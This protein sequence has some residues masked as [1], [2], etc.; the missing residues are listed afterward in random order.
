MTEADFEK[1]ITYAIQNWTTEYNQTRNFEPDRWVREAIQQAYIDGY[2]A[3]FE[4]SV[5][6]ERG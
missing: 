6:R 4:E 3:G 1:L 2:A 5:R